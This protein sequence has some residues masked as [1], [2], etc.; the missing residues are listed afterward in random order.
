MFVNGNV[1]YDCT[2]DDNASGRADSTSTIR[3]SDEADNPR[4]KAANADLHFSSNVKQ[5]SEN[6]GRYLGWLH[7]KLPIKLNRVTSVLSLIWGL[8]ALP[9]SKKSI[10]SITLTQ[11]VEMENLSVQRIYFKKFLASEHLRIFQF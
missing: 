2:T 7:T 10:S 4:I 5:D 9:R 1:D 8:S 3:S 11:K 6:K